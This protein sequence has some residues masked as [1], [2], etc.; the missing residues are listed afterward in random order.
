MYDYHLYLKVYFTLLEKNAKLL[1]RAF[2][3]FNFISSYK[4]LF[5][6][7]LKFSLS[8]YSFCNKQL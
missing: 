3:T 8:L 5:T 6:T 2:L 7:F 4:L 1:S